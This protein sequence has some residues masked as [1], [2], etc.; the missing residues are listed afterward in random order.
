MSPS[1]AQR[2]SSSPY[3]RAY[4]RIAASTLRMCRRSCSDWVIDVTSSQASS[5]VGVWVAKSHLLQGFEQAVVL[6]ARADGDAKPARDRIEIVPAHEDAALAQRVGHRRAVPARRRLDEKEVG[7]R[8]PHL[9]ALLAQ[10]VAEP[11]A[12][13]DDVVDDLLVVRVIFDRGHRRGD[14]D[15]VE[16]VRVHKKIVDHVVSEREW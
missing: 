12:L 7:S 11:F 15:A 5:R 16:V 8:R 2:S 13:G 9:E 3:F 10:A 6:I 4:A 1:T 14:G